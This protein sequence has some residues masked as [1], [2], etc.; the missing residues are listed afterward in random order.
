MRRI[1]PEIDPTWR[2]SQQ[3]APR[4]LISHLSSRVRNRLDSHTLPQTRT[5]R[6]G[7][8]LKIEASELIFSERSERRHEYNFWTVSWLNFCASASGYSHPF[9]LEV[10]RVHDVFLIG[11]HRRS[12]SELCRHC[13]R[14]QLHA[15][16]LIVVKKYRMLKV[17]PGSIVH[18][19]ALL[20]A[21]GIS[22]VHLVT[23][24]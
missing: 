6:A 12:A 5:C 21:Y 13:R 1:V 10:S 3:A 15:P 22:R 8:T 23:C 17:F 20:K 7:C 19:K 14:T 11:A 16:T 18:N 4:C 9:M 2:G 24:L